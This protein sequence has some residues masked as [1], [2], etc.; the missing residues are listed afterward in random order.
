MQHAATADIVV[1]A[2]AVADYTPTVVAG[3]K[4]AKADGDLTLVLRRT[5][6]I[7]KALG[8]RRA[9]SGGP[10]VLVGFAAETEDVVA[11]ARR[12]LE[13]KQVD[14]IVANDV[15]RVD[16]GFDVD[17]N[18]VTLVSQSG[19]E[20]VPLQ[21]KARIAAVILDRAEQLLLVRRAVPPTPDPLKV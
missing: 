17:S 7:L 10:A 18:A 13:L 21:S 4:V 15:S 5:P 3:Q 20:D 19:T 9:A 1:M 12:K 8:Q 11:R 6:D 14:L 2:A 16:A